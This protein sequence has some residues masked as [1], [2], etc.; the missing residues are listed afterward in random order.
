MAVGTGYRAILRLAEGENAID[1]AESQLHAWLLEKK[2]RNKSLDAA[3][4]SGEGTHELGPDARLVVVYGPDAQDGSRRRLYRFTEENTTGAW[5][6]SV[7]ALSSPYAREYHESL[8]VEA[9]VDGR[10]D[11]NPVDI[12]DP[13]RLVRR[14]LEAHSAWDSRVQL[15]GRPELVRPVDIE[16]VRQAICDD[17][18]TAS[19][20]VASSAWREHEER[21]RKV[22]ESLTKD[23]VGVAAAYVVDDEAA[24]LLNR[25]LPASHIVRP[26]AVRTYAPS[27]DLTS[28][29]DGLRHRILFPG[30]LARSL[31][32]TRVARPLSKKHALG[33]RLRFLERNL[34]SDVKRGMEVLLRAERSASRSWEATR[35]I[36]EPT[37]G[38]STPKAVGRGPSLEAEAA[39]TDLATRLAELVNRWTGATPNAVGLSVVDKL[40]EILQRQAAELEV[41]EEQ[42]DVATRRLD[43]SEQDLRDFR[44]R[45]EDVSLDL[46][47]S[48]DRIRELTREVVQLRQ[49]LVDAGRAEDTYVA[50]LADIWDP[51]DDILGLIT[52]IS[53]GL[54]THQAFERVEFT[55]DEDAAL[56]VDLHEKT[57]RYAHA[58][59]DYVH[60]LYD[61]A[62][63]KAAGRFSC[64]VH[65]YLKSDGIGGHKCSP[66]RHA[67]TESE[68]V[69]NRRAWREERVFSVPRS[70]EPSGKVLMAAHFKPTWRDTFAPRMHYFDDTD[71]SGK[72]YIGYIGRHLTNTKT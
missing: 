12:V 63:G 27:V 57:P 5:S 30:T 24:E 34:P 69:L 2:Q 49:R 61:Y 65:T 60:V 46:T 38:T 20:I 28:P 50:P 36:A 56:E 1:V 3:D 21:W 9:G 23:S 6:V 18:R 55:G 25:Y 70:V 19:V 52:R 39:H 40:D 33:A 67:A 64:G 59:W 32:G 48:D 13:P 17:K 54:D 51:P 14:I 42:V 68:S 4:W 11:A 10:D 58:F 43:Q 22:V 15:T 29:E 35:R 45:L 53:P 66:D 72:I 26:G 16:L 71:R 47:V 7:F 37:G 31:S 44:S 41:A 8:I 62:T